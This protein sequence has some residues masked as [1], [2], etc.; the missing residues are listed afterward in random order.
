MNA[1]LILL[2]LVLTLTTSLAQ[3]STEKLEL[4]GDTFE[5]SDGSILL[6]NGEELKGLVKYNDRNGVLAYHD[7]DNSRPFTP[8]SVLGFEF[9]DE[10]KQKQR[11]FYSLEDIDA[12]T[13]VK[14]PL[15]F[16]L[17][18][19][20]KTFAIVLR[21]DRT[22][23]RERHN[24]SPDFYGNG[25][26]TGGSTT[27]TLELSQTQTVCILNDKGEVFPYFKCISLEDGRRSWTTGED[28]KTKNKM[29]HNDLLLNFIEKPHYSQLISYA[30]ENKLDFKKLDNFKKI[31]E[32]YD[33]LIS[34]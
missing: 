19:D 24:S 27:S 2:I 18:R 4:L 23:V 14:R 9:F 22:E 1:R 34:N 10:Q 28:V 33:T 17:L 11:I 6:S 30:D 32:Y 25:I 13:N 3:T 29:I 7:G 20:Y 12:E 26:Y 21:I 15:F 8:R 16:E 31:L 5:W